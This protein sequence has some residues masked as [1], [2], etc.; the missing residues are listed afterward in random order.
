MAKGT[1]DYQTAIQISYVEIEG[2]DFLTIRPAYGESKRFFG[3]VSCGASATTELVEVTGR[4]V[5]I[6]AY[7]RW[8][9]ASS[10]SSIQPIIKCEDVVIFQYAANVL[11]ARK[12]YDPSLLPLYLIQFD[13]TDFEYIVGVQPGITFETSF[14][15][16]I[17][18]PYGGSISVY[19][20][21]CFALTP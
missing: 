4:G 15:M 18:N 1:R 7:F 19:Y 14:K 6:G 17:Q 16:E 11:N 21:I 10:W 8:T 5:V 2:L 20:D 13:D 3:S 12:I 9:A